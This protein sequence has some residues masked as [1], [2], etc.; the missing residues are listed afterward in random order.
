MGNKFVPVAHSRAFAFHK[1]EAVEQTAWTKTTN[2]RT[3]KDKDIPF[4]PIRRRLQRPPRLAGKKNDQQTTAD[5]QDEFARVQK[6]ADNGQLDEAALLCEKYVRQSNPSAK[7]YYLL[8]VIRDS[9]GRTEEAKQHFRRAVYLDPSNVESL[10][11]LALL[12]EKAGNFES[13]ENYTRRVRM[14]QKKG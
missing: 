5:P 13:A 2:I 9:Q 7:W 12:A 10:V 6:L 11:Q 3:E 4:S 1:L 8:G 14:I